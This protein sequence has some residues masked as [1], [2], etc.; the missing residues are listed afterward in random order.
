LPSPPRLIMAA[1]AH[2]CS[3]YAFIFS[4]FLF[5]SCKD[6]VNLAILVSTGALFLLFNPPLSITRFLLG[7]YIITMFLV[8]LHVNK[9]QKLA[10]VAAL[11]LSQGSLFAYVSYLSRGD[12][13]SEFKFS[14]VEYYLTSGDFD[15]F[16][17]TIN[18][19]SMHDNVGGKGGVNLLSAV[20][21][22]VPRNVWPTKSIGTGGEGAM[23]EGYPFFNISSPLPSEF[24]VDFGM[25]GVV[26]L[27]LLFG[28]FVRLSD[29]YFMVFKK[30]SDAVGQ[31]FFA[32]AA[33]FVFIILRG[34]LVGTLGPIVLSLAIVGICY[35]YST[36]PRSTFPDG[37]PYDDED[38][39][40]SVGN[41]P[42]HRF[43]YDV[44]K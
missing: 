39:V 11:V 18:I 23:Y 38:G 17:S 15:G 21:F 40:G 3:F 24:Y 37:A 32:T 41:P 4:V 42:S 20:F 8:F 31:L 16:Q 36:A 2:S 44:E 29:D 28:L 1:I 14:P 9:I 7:S 34:S 5:R 33:G 6:L 43:R 12:L 35:R 26:V 10:L 13:N 22:F 19:V 27:S 30:A 25:L